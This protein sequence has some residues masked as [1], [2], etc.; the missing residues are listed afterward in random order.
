MSLR[1]IAIGVSAL[2]IF[3]MHGG[4]QESHSTAQKSPA[5]VVTISDQDNGK[6]IDLPQGATLLVKLTSNPS[7][8]YSWAVK[9]DPSPLKLE[10]TSTKKGK[11]SSKKVGAPG[12]QELRFVASSAGMAS[13]TLEYRRPWEYNVAPAKTFSARVNVR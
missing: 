6:D 12:V 7:T 4:A 9:G 8:G 1:S 10:K 3:T 5:S 11:Q 13:L 2:L